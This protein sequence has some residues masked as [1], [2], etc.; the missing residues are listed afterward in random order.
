[1]MSWQ[2]DIIRRNVAAVQMI[3][4]GS[5]IWQENS[6]T[7]LSDFREIYAR[8]YSVMPVNT[9]FVKHG[10]KEGGYVTQ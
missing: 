8:Q 2:L 6:S 10:V 7:F 3:G 9:Q 5:D 4:A 1:M